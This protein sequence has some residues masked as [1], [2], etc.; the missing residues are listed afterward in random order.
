MQY[1]LRLI[2]K[3]LNPSLMC[4]LLRCMNNVICDDHDVLQ[5]RSLFSVIQ[6]SSIAN[7]STKRG[8]FDIKPSGRGPVSG[9]FD[10]IVK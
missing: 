2:S 5:R 7:L 4:S 1:N 3:L 8:Y 6:R 10:G 9:S